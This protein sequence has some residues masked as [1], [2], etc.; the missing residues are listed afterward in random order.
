VGRADRPAEVGAEDAKQP[1]T[2]GDFLPIEANSLYVTPEKGVAPAPNRWPS[3]I[4]K[5][6]ISQETRLLSCERPRDSKNT[7]IWTEE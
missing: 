3:V 5:R 6:M 7:M 2:G 1:Q 4:K